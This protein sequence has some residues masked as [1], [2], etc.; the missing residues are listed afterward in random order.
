VDAALFIARLL[1]AAVFVLAAAAKLA[2][3]ATARRAFEDFGVPSPLTGWLSIAV[4]LV[5]LAVAVSLVPNAT[6]QVAG[7]AALALLLLFSAAIALNLARGRKPDCACFGQVQSAP[8]GGTTLLR[9]GVLAAVSAGILVGGPG[10]AGDAFGWLGDLRTAEAVGLGM[11]L[12]LAGAVAV[13]SWI[14]FN[15]VRQNGRLLLRLDRIE[16]AWGMA[17]GTAGLPRGARAPDFSLPD[18]SGKIVTLESLLVGGRPVVLAFTDPE[19]GPCSELLPEVARGQREHRERLTIALI[20][21]DADNARE[22][23]AQHGLEQVLMQRELEVFEA[24]RAPGFPSAVLIDTDGTIASEVVYGLD[25]VGAL[26][27]EAA[28]RAAAPPLVRIDGDAPAAPT[29]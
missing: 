4:P 21:R 11:G 26:V 19:C 10:D 29:A 3:R 1:L 17:P 18:L 24:F 20:A 13:L 6:A 23:A 25:Q 8:I 16:E 28:E 2:D 15:L 9:N 22:Q 14:V 5:E 7:G 12:A 27:A